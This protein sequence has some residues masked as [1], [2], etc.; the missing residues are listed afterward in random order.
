LEF[1]K[2]RRER[3]EKTEECGAKEVEVLQQNGII[4]NHKP[5]RIFRDQRGC[6]ADDDAL[7]S[8]ESKEAALGWERKAAF[9]LFPKTGAMK[10]GDS[11]SL[12]PAATAA[13]AYTP[14]LTTVVRSPGSQAPRFLHR[15]TLLA[16]AP[17]STAFQLSLSLSLSLCLSPAVSLK[18]R[19][20]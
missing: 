15:F 11:G 13:A 17:R 1:W 16:T 9:L 5:S 19:R 3:G 4:V 2:D 10:A 18:S 12:Q 8:H 20:I 7:V 14:A 6:E